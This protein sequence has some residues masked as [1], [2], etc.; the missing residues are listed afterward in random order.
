[1]VPLTFHTEYSRAVTAQLDDTRA[2]CSEMSCTDLLNIF[3]QSSLGSP[4][5]QDKA[6]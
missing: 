3:Q 1:M 4:W 2:T 6:L 5:R